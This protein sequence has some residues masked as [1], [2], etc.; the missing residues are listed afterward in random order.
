V[1]YDG[2]NW[3]IMSALAYIEQRLP[4]H[5]RAALKDVRIIED[6]SIKGAWA[7][8]DD[9]TVY[10][11]S[12]PRFSSQVGVGILVHELGHIAGAHYAR[13][14]AGL[15]SREEAEEEADRYARSWGFGDELRE[16]AVFL[17]R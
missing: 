3:D 17:G 9:Q 5:V 1:R 7:Q 2:L 15:L 8:A 14:D 10:V 13:V 12:L 6:G 4:H 16:R 11:H